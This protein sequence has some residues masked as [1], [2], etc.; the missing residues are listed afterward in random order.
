[1]KINA[2][3][4]KYANKQS[5]I[6][7]ESVSKAFPSAQRDISDAQDCLVAG[8]DTATVFHLMRVVEWGIRAFCVHLGITRLKKKTRA[9]G[10]VVY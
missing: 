6:F 4:M 3:R 2:D 1:M 5:S 9:N 10:T 8:C 7:P